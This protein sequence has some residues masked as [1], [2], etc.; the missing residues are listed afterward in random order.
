MFQSLE[1]WAPYLLCWFHFQC[2][3]QVA[4]LSIVAQTVLE[5]ARD[6]FGPLFGCRRPTKPC[7]DLNA[8]FRISSEPTVFSEQRFQRITIIEF[9]AQSLINQGPGAI[10]RI[11]YVHKR[12]DLRRLADS[13]HSQHHKSTTVTYVWRSFLAIL[14]LLFTNDRTKGM[15]LMLGKMSS[16]TIV[17]CRD[18]VVSL[19]S[20]T[21][22]HIKPFTGKTKRVNN[23]PNYRSPSKANVVSPTSLGTFLCFHICTTSTTPDSEGDVIT[24]GSVSN[25]TLLTP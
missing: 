17:N 3:R 21:S 8:L 5:H 19:N 11:E 22:L 2:H 13:Y 12:S 6:I 24:A 1:L 7:S 18:T 15:Y 9:I 23:Y 14:K 16:A 25:V 4:P 20:A 10:N